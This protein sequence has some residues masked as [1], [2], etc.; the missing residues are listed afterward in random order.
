MLRASWGAPGG[1]TEFGEVRRDLARVRAGYL[2][3][4][5]LELRCRPI[6]SACGPLHVLGRSASPQDQQGSQVQGDRRHEDAKAYGLETP[7]TV[8]FQTQHFL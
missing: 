8:I 1:F 7:Q 5:A 6:P 2:P 3:L 4:S